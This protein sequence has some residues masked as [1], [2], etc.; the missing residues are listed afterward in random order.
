MNQQ[1][2]RG[3]ELRKD[4]YM[5]NTKLKA[6]GALLVLA[7]VV[8][9]AQS[10]GDYARAARKNKD[11]AEVVPASRQFDNDNLPTDAQLSVVGPPADSAASDKPANGPSAA[12]DPAAERQKA[13]D[14]LNKKIE[15]QRVKVDALNHEL[16]LVQ[17]EY[18]L[19][20]AEMY[21]DPTNRLHNPAEWQSDD[22]KFKAD[23]DTKQK[24]LDTAKSDL[25]SMQ[26]Q[27]H[28]AGIA[29]VSDKDNGKSQDKSNDQG[30][31]QDQSQD[32]DK[33]KQ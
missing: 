3:R 28:K 13:A 4:D 1:P 5:K 23:I 22:A 6:I 16:D 9:S 11:N 30:K 20:A 18:R 25:D 26:E 14:E 7:S 8:A 17:R 10:L 19:R 27:A 15:E 12:V 2:A 21:S 29:P 33:S 24:A 31:G 32:Q